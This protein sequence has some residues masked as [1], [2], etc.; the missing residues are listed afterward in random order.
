MNAVW[1]SVVRC[2]AVWYSVVK[3]NVYSS[4]AFD[5]GARMKSVAVCFSV[6]LCV[7]LCCCVVLCVAVR[8]SVTQLQ[9]I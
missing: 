2:G 5:E 9:A 3:C 7:T 4:N 8:C 1:C 6:L